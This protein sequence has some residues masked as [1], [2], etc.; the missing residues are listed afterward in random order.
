MRAFKFG[1]TRRRETEPGSRPPPLYAAH[2]MRELVIAPDDP[3][4]AD[5]VALLQRHLAFAN[6]HSPP[7]DVH[8]LDLDGLLDPAVTFFS[9]RRDGA[10]LA[11][12]ALKRLDDTHVELKSMH[13]AE[14]AR[15]QGVAR[16]MLDHLLRAARRGG[17]E[18]AS[19]ET[20]SMDAFEPARALYASVGFATC[21]PFGDYSPSPNSTFMTL[22]LAADDPAA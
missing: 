7:E 2:D 17:Y 5:V 10:L 16:A 20:G 4:V 22:V 15:G 6:A 13:T 11:I 9:A 8:A 12:G 1:D 18:R 3:R 19:L 21:S 14:S